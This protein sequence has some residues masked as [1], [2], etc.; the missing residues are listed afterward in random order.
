MLPDGSSLLSEFDETLSSEL[1]EVSPELDDAVVAVVLLAVLVL[2]SRPR[3]RMSATHT[4]ASTTTPATISA[5][6]VFLSYFGGWPPA[7]PGWPY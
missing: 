2:W 6:T 4:A 3:T 1:D 5:I 7:P